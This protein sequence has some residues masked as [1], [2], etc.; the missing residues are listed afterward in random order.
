MIELGGNITL[1]GFENL[2]PGALII[3]KKV[4]GNY[5]KKISNNIS[6]FEKILICLNKLDFNHHV[7]VKLQSNG[8]IDIQEAADSNLF[9]ALDKALS[10]FNSY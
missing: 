4:V 6:N 2:E 10:K 9:F 3:V 7:Q 8:E 5:T 1:E